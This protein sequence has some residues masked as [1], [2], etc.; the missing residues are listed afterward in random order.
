MGKQWL[1]LTTCPM[2]KSSVVRS[3]LYWENIFIWKEVTRL[4]YFGYLIPSISFPVS[5]VF[6]VLTAETLTLHGRELP[7]VFTLPLRFTALTKGTLTYFSILGRIVKLNPHL[8]F[9]LSSYWASIISCAYV[10]LFSHFPCVLG[11]Y[12]LNVSCK[13]IQPVSVLHF[14][15]WT[16]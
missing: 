12:D 3:K 15:P 10:Q 13:A 9:I 11:L 2:V 14:P 7:V 5:T 8:H 1:C 6:F 4:R 16:N